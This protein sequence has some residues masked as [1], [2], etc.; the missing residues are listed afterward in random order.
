MPSRPL[1]Y[2]SSVLAVAVFAGLVWIAWPAKQSAAPTTNNI[3][4][5]T[6]A[7]AQVN[8]S[9]NTEA[10]DTPITVPDGM[11]T[12]STS[13]VPNRDA[14][15]EF[16]I[17]IP[18]SWR[19]EYV[20]EQHAINIYDPAISTSSTI[21]QSRLF[22]TSL[23]V[24]QSEVGVGWEASNAVSTSTATL[25]RT[26]ETLSP[27]GMVERN[28]FLPMFVRGTHAVSLLEPV[29]AG[30]SARYLVA[31]HGDIPAATWNA[32]IASFAPNAL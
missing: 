2:V 10:I 27:T 7:S 20:P 22:I 21:E 12:F 29:V 28:A 15:L 11:M 1:F 18:T 5:N 25:K 16:S 14:A 30:A 17:A 6:A 23:A 31:H 8:T 9:T 26:D 24:G 4:L 13:D 3:N 32:M 19:A